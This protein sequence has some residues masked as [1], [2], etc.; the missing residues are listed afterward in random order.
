MN[1]I[2][3]SVAEQSDAQ[4]IYDVMQEVYDRL[5]N[6]TLY[7]C[8]DLDYVKNHVSDEGMTV[9]ARNKDGKIIGSFM[10]RYPGVSDDNLGRDIALDETE[11]GKV[12]HMESAVVSPEY[13]GNELQLKMLQYAEKIIDTNKYKY[14]MSTV[15]PDNP[16]SYRSL[17]K[18]GYELVKTK[19]KYGGLLR[20]IY[21][22]KV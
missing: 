12:V 19:E 4:E 10:F 3:I 21:L 20:R 9:I 17:E 15:S 8:D 1:D 14:F 16:A 2:I 13:R 18:S 22:K 7:V 11:L 6:K 5:E